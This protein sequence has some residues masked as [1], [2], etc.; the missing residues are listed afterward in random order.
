MLTVHHLAIS[1]SER[2]VWLCEELELPYQL[3]RYSRDPETGLAPADYKALHPAGTAPIITDGKLVLAESGA[4]MEY[5]IAKH[6]NGRLSVALDDP[7]FAE[8]LFWFHFANA[9]M[10]PSQ[11]ACVMA[12][13]GGVD[14]SRI[15]RAMRARGDKVFDFVERRLANVDYFAGGAFTAADIIMFF[16]LT[17]RAGARMHLFAPYDL[18]PFPNIRVELSPVLKT[19]SLGV[20]MEPEVGHDETDIYTRVQT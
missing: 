12:S 5:I 10:M 15:S 19:P 6:G 2:I 18:A 13:A 8:Y 9:S 14:E 3:V 1:Q 20:F 11:I 16:P 4:I 7:N 17:W